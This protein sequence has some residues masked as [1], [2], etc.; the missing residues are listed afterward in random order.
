M[1]PRWPR[2][3]SVIPTLTGGSA[4]A[5]FGCASA[6]GGNPTNDGTTAEAIAALVTKSRLVI[7]MV[8]RS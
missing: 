3:Q 4:S 5:A 2:F 1:S 7:N 6:R 8:P